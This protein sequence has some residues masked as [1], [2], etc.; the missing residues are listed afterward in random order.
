MTGKVIIVAN[1]DIKDPHFYK[2]LQQDKD[3]VICVNGGTAHALAIG[4]E[5]DLV[6]GDLDSLSAADRQ[7]IG[8]F[9]TRFDEF[10]AQKEKSDLELAI[11]RAVAMKPREILIIGAL[12][13]KRVEHLFINLLLLAIPLRHLIPASII[14]ETTLIR[15][16]D[17]Y[18]VVK[19]SPGD[20]LSLFALKQEAT[21]VTTSGLKYPLTAENLS[22]SSTRGL[23]NE[24]ISSEATIEVEDGLIL[25]I[26]TSRSAI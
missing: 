19:G 12:G 7:A 26:K 23:S 6:L 3:Y 8:R 9:N 11:E 4:L 14:D 5:P 15:L 20:Y 21:G 22:F 17:R 18:A 24:L 10:P 13:G 2:A 25:L 16:I 1:G